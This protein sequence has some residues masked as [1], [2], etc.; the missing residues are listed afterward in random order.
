M[1]SAPEK[2][3]AGLEEMF[4]MKQWGNYPLYEYIYYFPEVFLVLRICVR[5]R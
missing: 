3:A 5:I 4:H 2:S 1:K